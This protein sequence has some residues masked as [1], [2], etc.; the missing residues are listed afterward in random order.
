MREGEGPGA[1]IHSHPLQVDRIIRATMGQI[2]AGNCDESKRPFMVQTFLQKYGRFFTQQPAST[3]PPLFGQDL[4]EAISKMPDNTPGLDGVRKGDLLILSPL[5]LDIIAD[6]L[7]A[8]EEGAAWPQPCNAVRTAFLS[9]EEDDLSPQGFRGLAILSKLYRMWAAIRLRHVDGW[10][11]SW[12]DQGLFAGCN[13]PVGA[14]DA[15]FLKPSSPRK[16]GSQENQ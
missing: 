1:P 5:C 12:S 16:P 6:L 2:Y 11:E 10:V 7:N 8:I 4:A 13:R 9:K 14:E 3:V 15:W